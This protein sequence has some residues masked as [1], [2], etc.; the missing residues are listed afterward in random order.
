MATYDRYDLFREDG[1]IKIVPYIPIPVKS[2]DI[3]V[4]YKKNKSR[5]DILSHQYYGNANY[6]WLIMQANPELGSMEFEIPDGSTL[7]IP[8]PL[9]PT[10]ERYIADANQYNILN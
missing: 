3:N 6:G 7:R 9:E 4:I 2:T 1:E 8:Y 10:I 5:L